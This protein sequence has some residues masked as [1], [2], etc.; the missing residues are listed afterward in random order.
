[1]EDEKLLEKID[2]KLENVVTVKIRENGAK[3][4]INRLPALVHFRN[5]IPLEYEGQ[6]EEKRVLKWISKNL[7]EKRLEKVSGKIVDFLIESRENVAILFYNDEGS[8]LTAEEEETLRNEAE[9]LNVFFAKTDDENKMAEFGLLDRR[10]PVLVYFEDGVPGLFSS[11]INADDVAWW[12]EKAKRSSSLPNVTDSVLE[13]FMLD[14][15]EFV[16]VFFSGQ[17]K[18][19]P[20]EC[21][22]IEDALIEIKHEE[23]SQSFLSM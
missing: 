2:A 5:G 16:G 11:D 8:T 12:L 15:F 17:C 19:D 9:T 4:G 10:F 6:F 1:M 18:A 7:S 21:R 3:Y 13:H 23:S 22:E 20:E 14:A